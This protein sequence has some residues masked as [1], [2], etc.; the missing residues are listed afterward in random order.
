ME[1]VSQLE[2]SKFPASIS[3]QFFCLI[4]Y[5][6]NGLIF[7]CGIFIAF[8]KPLPGL[9]VLSVTMPV[10]WVV[11]RRE[12]EKPAGMALL[13][14]S[15]LNSIFFAMSCLIFFTGRVDMFASFVFLFL[16]M[17]LF[18]MTKDYQSHTDC[19][20][21]A[22]PLI[23][24][25]LLGT[26]FLAAYKHTGEVLPLAALL[27]MGA[28]GFILW[29]ARGITPASKRLLYYTSGYLT[30]SLLSA[31]AIGAQNLSL[32][33]LFLLI[34]AFALAMQLAREGKLS[35]EKIIRSSFLASLIFLFLYLEVGVLL[36]AILIYVI[37]WVNKPQISDLQEQQGWRFG[38]IMWM[39]VV[40]MG[41]VFYLGVMAGRADDARLK[42]IAALQK[43][44][45][46]P[47]QE[48]AP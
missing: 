12:M 33:V 37:F 18:Y 42:R 20:D 14:A 24:I 4:V 11:Y 3:Q 46:A 26:Y 21:S 8:Y 40:G 29:V 30:L 10:L 13:F 2:N 35:L 28:G 7:L 9:L 45:R 19:G 31:Y 32:P 16:M 39:F 47:E 15:I 5:T 48:A 43:G 25:F 44:D 34:G 41:L 22:L 6:F 17:N 1:E 27:F 38:T 36:L 23:T